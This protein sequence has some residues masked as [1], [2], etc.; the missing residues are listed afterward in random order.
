MKK[1]DLASLALLGIS[2]AL[3]IAGCQ[4]PAKNGTASP[5]GQMQSQTVMSPEMQSFYSSLNADGQRK[6]NSLDAKHQAMAM[7]MASQSCNGK[8]DCKGMGGCSNQN[9]SCAGKNACKGQG[10]APAKDPNKAVDAQ[11]TNQ[12]AQRDAV[13]Y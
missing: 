7:K 1:R 4:Q 5:Q 12:T 3:L 13:N 9:N 10:G 2:S 6:F 11:Y 8:N